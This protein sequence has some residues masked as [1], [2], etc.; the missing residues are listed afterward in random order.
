MQLTEAQQP[1]VRGYSQYPP[2]AVQNSDRGEGETA[3]APLPQ[4]ELERR[5]PSLTPP[6]PGHFVS[7]RFESDCAR[8]VGEAKK[9]A[10]SRA[11][12]F[13]RPS[14]AFN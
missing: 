6:L 9:L 4:A 5:T 11:E 10:R 8:F 12:A 14:A 7:T 2:V 1:P 13:S 3:L